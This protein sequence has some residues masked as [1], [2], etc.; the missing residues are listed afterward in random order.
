PIV[1]YGASDKE[2]ASAAKTLK[3]LG[4]RRVTIYSGGASAWSGSAE[5]LE[6]GAAKDEIPAS[7]KSHD[8]RLTGR[9]F[10][11]ALVSPV[12]VEI[13]D[14]RSEAEQKSSG[15][16]KSKKISLQSLAKRYGELDRD[17][18]QVLFAADSMRAEMGYD[19]LRS[20]GYRVNYLSGSVEFEKDGKYK[21]TD[22]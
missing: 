17:K 13:I 2:A 10:E 16:P 5:A 18:I 11:M 3:E 12:M 15:F 22:E 20:K 19:F 1:I 8:G 21:L 4:F 9:D 7:S 6:K 14:L